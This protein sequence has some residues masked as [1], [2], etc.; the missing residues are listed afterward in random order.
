MAGKALNL[1][2]GFTTTIIL[3][4][5]AIYLTINNTETKS[6]V[7]EL[8][9]ADN[10]EILKKDASNKGAWDK[11]WEQFKVAYEKLKTK[12]EW[13]FESFEQAIKGSPNA[14]EEFKTRCENN[15]QK[16]VASKKDPLYDEVL[17]YCVGNK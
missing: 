5:F 16:Q 15:G 11:N 1:L 6:T 7:I 8:L 14:P 10:K 4:A 9:K 12:E 2:G 13:K 17:K 3:G